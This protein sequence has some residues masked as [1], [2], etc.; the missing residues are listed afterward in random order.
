LAGGLNNNSL[1]K[2]ESVISL[3]ER[4][5]SEALV[6]LEALSRGSGIEPQVVASLRQLT[7]LNDDARF[8]EILAQQVA[9]FADERRRLLARICGNDGWESWQPMPQTCEEQHTVD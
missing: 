3:L 8:D 4:R 7:P 6:A 9:H 2:L 1:R 5:Q